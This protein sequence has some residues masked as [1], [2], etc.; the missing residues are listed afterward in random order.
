MLMQFSESD[1]ERLF[2]FYDP[3]I[4][5]Y[6]PDDARALRWSEREG[7]VER[8]RVL[9]E[10]GVADGASVLDVGCGFG[11]LHQ[12]IAERYRNISYLGIDINP[13]M[14]DVARQ[15][16]PAASF[17]A[18][19]FGAWP[20]D[21]LRS[22][23]G[24]EIRGKQQFDFV[25]ASGTFSFKIEQYRDIYFRYIRKMFETTRVAAAFN[26][27]DARHHIDDDIFATYWPE[28]MYAF[29]LGL[30]PRVEMRDAYLR[31][32]FTIYMYK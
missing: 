29:C 6:G 2:G 19:D 7:Q 27:L 23:S 24:Q 3:A 30:T 32:D 14:I 5:G 8:F 1:K 31:Y 18:A 22:D 11:D 25:L 17:E 20:L 13:H 4:E 16:Y 15:K 10:A 9:C 21:T 28:E 12:Y 26:L